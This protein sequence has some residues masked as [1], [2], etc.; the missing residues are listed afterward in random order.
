[1]NFKLVK[2]DDFS[3]EETSFYSPYVEAFGETLFDR[4]IRENLSSYQNEVMDILER[5]EVI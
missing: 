2:L 3:G 1:V 4:F 5:M